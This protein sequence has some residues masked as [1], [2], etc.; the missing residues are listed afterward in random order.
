MFR[1][2]GNNFF[3]YVSIVFLITAVFIELLNGFNL[4][5][6]SSSWHVPLSIFA[7]RLI[8]TFFYGMLV[9]TFLSVYNYGVRKILY[10]LCQPPLVFFNIFALV[11]LISSLFAKSIPGA[12]VDINIQHAIRLI[13]FFVTIS[14]LPVAFIKNIVQVRKLFYTLIFFLCLRVSLAV[15]GGFI[16]TDF[17]ILEW[18]QSLSLIIDYQ[19]FRIALTNIKVNPFAMQINSLS[20]VAAIIFLVFLNSFL[21]NRHKR[22]RILFFIITALLFYFLLQFKVTQTTYVTVLLGILIVVVAR[23]RWWSVPFSMFFGLFVL[24]NN[25]F[26]VN[27]YMRGKSISWL[28]ANDSRMS[29]LFPAGWQGFLESPIYGHGYMSGEAVA[30][31]INSIG[32]NVEI[33]NSILSIAFNTGLLGLLP[34]VL[35]LCLL[36]FITIRFWI[37]SSMNMFSTNVLL[38]WMSSVISSI[39]YTD[40]WYKF[41][42]YLMIRMLPF[43]MVLV[44]CHYIYNVYWNTE[45]NEK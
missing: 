13:A 2:I 8:N 26:L 4:L 33:H 35:G 36:T 29:H 6:K 9:C 27:Y 38:V 37:G 18:Y 12:P 43:F 23:L 31:S 24:I 3:S 32:R 5:P 16:A 14:L 39:T 7:Y 17:S 40:V 21:A 28:I 25:S 20:W 19:T 22:F 15:V 34:F 11:C 1:T 41:D 10:F 45:E 30:A 44:T 42:D